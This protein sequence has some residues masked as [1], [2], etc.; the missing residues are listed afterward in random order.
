MVDA[1]V[2]MKNIENSDAA[3]KLL[4]D[5]K[6]E[7]D[8]VLKAR[9][10]GVNRLIEMCCCD[11]RNLGTNLGV[12]GWCKAMR[13]GKRADTIALRLREPKT[14]KFHS[15]DHLLKIMWHEM[16]HITHGNHSAVFYALMEEI[17]RH[18]ELIIS[19]GR[20]IIDM[21]GFPIGGGQS[22]GG[23]RAGSSALAKQRALE[24]ASK[25]QKWNN[26]TGVHSLGG[27]RLALPPR[28]A[29]ARAAQLRADDLSRG[30]GDAELLPDD[31]D[32]WCVW[33]GPVCFGKSYHKLG[34]GVQ[35]TEIKKQNQ[36][37]LPRKKR[38]P[39]DVLDLTNED[40]DDEAIAQK[41]IHKKKSSKH[42]P[43]A[44]KKPPVVDLT[45]LDDDD[46]D[47]IS[48]FW[49]CVE[50]TLQNP[51]NVDH[52]QACYLPRQVRRQR[53]HQQKK[54]IEPIPFDPCKSSLNGLQDFRRSRLH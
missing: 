4:L 41:K 19:R 2:E 15:R 13:R 16:S 40:D 51:C 33:C 1:V 46:D 44:K 37:K 36:T 11:R 53:H 32:D 22:L 48:N 9:G 18:Y 21:D 45:T 31:D 20:R 24:A 54:A 7:V 43:A 35:I 26:Q 8:L 23:T 39:P 29:A 52:C 28:E 47:L 38:G 30:L 10:L 6:Q 50:C 14:H 12:G 3:R 34:G 27:Q 49:T 42:P 25:R 17:G 5:I